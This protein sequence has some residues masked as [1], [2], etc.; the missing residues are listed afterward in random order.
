RR[1]RDSNRPRAE[2]RER[3]KSK[4][5]AVGKREHATQADRKRRGVSGVR[6]RAKPFSKRN[7]RL[8]NAE[9]RRANVSAGDRSRSE[10][11]SRLRRLFAT[12]K[13]DFSYL[14][15]DAGAPR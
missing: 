13:L 4:T 5:V 7:G 6:S 9:A 3:T 2:D 15:A 11:C 14:R 12:R 1:L 8:R 10:I